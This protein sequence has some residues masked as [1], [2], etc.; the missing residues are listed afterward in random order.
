MLQ[1]A[2]QALHDMLERSTRFD[3][4]QLADAA[5]AG[6]SRRA[7]NILDSLLLTGTEPILILWA[8]ARDLRLLTRCVHEHAKGIGLVCDFQFIL[9]PG[10]KRKPLLQAAIQ[11][12]DSASCQK[13]LM[14]AALL[15]QIIKGAAPGNTRDAL[16]SLTEGLAGK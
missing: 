2:G 6:N 12:H 16:F 3:I 8:L 15:D 4:F 11:R 1:Q 13:W 5:L 10:K 14:Q 9:C 7:L